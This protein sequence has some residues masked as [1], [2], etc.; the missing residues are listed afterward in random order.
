[1][2]YHKEI[3]LA[4]LSYRNVVIYLVSHLVFVYY[5]FE[6]MRTA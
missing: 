3:V 2:I 4:S 1:M 5:H 6:S